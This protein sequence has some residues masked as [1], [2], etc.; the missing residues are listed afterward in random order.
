MSL[1][2]IYLLM[3]SA[4]G[5]V[6]SCFARNRLI[7]PSTRAD[8]LLAVDTASLPL[9]SLISNSVMSSALMKEHNSC[10]SAKQFLQLTYQCPYPSAT[11]I[12]KL[13]QF[14]KV[15]IVGIHLCLKLSYAGILIYF[16]SL[17]VYLPEW[18]DVDVLSVS[19]S[20]LSKLS[21]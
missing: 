8:N 2:F 15:C 18:T 4:N 7:C 11:I 21:F 10:H 3:K 12:P 1:L 20:H 5:R 19:Y 13:L 14:L 6:C 16:T 17:A 9:W